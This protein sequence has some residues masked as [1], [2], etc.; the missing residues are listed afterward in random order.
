M[1]NIELLLSQQTEWA[2]L[3]KEQKKK[4]KLE[5]GRAEKRRWREMK[6]KEMLK[7]DESKD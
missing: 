6:V 7:L 2:I 5:K 3:Y 1:I 4:I